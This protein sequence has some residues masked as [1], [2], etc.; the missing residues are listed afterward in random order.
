M[1]VVA[2]SAGVKEWDATNSTF[3]DGLAAFAEKSGWKFQMHNRMWSDDNVYATQNGGKYKFIVEPQ[4]TA[5]NCRLGFQEF[6]TCLTQPDPDG[7][8]HFQSIDS[9]GFGHFRSCSKH[10]QRDLAEV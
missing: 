7:L 6:E 2:H 3:P 8:G 4:V 9:G 10:C 1:I 5:R